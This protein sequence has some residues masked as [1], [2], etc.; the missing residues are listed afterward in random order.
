MSRSSAGRKED[1]RLRVA[2]SLGF[3]VSQRV[4]REDRLGVVPVCVVDSG[5]VTQVGEG[6]LLDEGDTGG[7]LVGGLGCLVAGRALAR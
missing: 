3:E 2:G 6:G 4:V 7:V 1:T 5:D